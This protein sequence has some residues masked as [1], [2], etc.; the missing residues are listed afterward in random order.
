MTDQTD[1]PRT[2]LWLIGARGAISTCVVY[3]IA[4]LRHGTIEPVGLSTEREPLRSLGLTPFDQFVL[5]GHDVCTR[6]VSQSAGELLE[7]GVLSPDLVASSVAE[8]TDFE[9]RLRPGILDEPDVGL[10]TLDPAAAELGSMAPLDQIAQVRADWDA[11]ER[12]NGLDRTIVV[13]VASTEAS[14]SADPDWNDLAALESALEGKQS[15]PASIIYAYAALGSDRPFVNFT[16][17]LGA[18]IGAL[19]ELARDKN[20]PHCG[21]DGKTGETLLKTTLAPMFLARALKV[22]SWQG[23]NMLGNRDGEVLREAGH[24][25]AKVKNKNDVLHS[26][27]KDQ[28]DLH[29]EVGIDYVPSLADWKTAWDFVHFEGFLG[30]K[31]SLQFTWSGSDSALAAPLIIDLARLTDFAARK[32][33]GGAMRHVACYFKNPIEGTT[34]DFHRQYTSLLEYAAHH[35]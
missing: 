31:M 14:R 28:P 27:F 4:G 24:K 6:S 16:P 35:S 5:G 10:A 21:S 25:E 2:G 13:Y 11:F 12:E 20:V 17:S 1:T 33:E 15:Q 26:I 19:L 3:G 7:T 32:G 22:L 23:Y 30:T 34:H 29:S 18:H 8:A 9:A